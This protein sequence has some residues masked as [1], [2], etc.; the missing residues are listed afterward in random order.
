LR[1]SERT[2]GRLDRG[3]GASLFGGLAS[4]GDL[5]DLCI[6]TLGGLFD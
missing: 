3:S 1:A 5:V 2:L 6:H 4:G